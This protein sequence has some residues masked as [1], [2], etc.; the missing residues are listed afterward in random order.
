MTQN[1]KNKNAN[2][3]RGIHTRVKTAK[4]RKVSSTQWLQ[5]QLNDPY[6]KQAKSDGYLARSA[7]KLIE[8]DDKYKF[9]KLK[10]VVVDLGAAPG[11]WCQVVSERVKSDKDDVRVVGI[12]YLEMAQIG[13]TKILKKDFLDPDAPEAIISALGGRAPDVILS[14]MAVPTT[15]HRKTDHLRTMALVEVALEFALDVLKPSGTFLTKTFR[16]GTQADLLNTLKRNFKTVHHIK[17]PASRA[18]S[19]ELYM[20]AMGRK[21]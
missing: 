13:G 14:D 3:N 7:Y 16:G 4:G 6:V 12:D 18:N 10:S 17:P 1:K 9:L 8:I 2:A 21:D 20:L 19:V 15:G 11:G 5:R